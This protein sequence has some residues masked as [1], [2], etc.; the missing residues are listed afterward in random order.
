MSIGM[1]TARG[2]WGGV[3][4]DAASTPVDVSWKKWDK[5]TRGADAAALA[6]P[7]YDDST[8]P[9][10]DPSG[11][12]LTT[13]RGDSWYRGTFNVTP[14]QVDSMME[15]PHFDPPPPVKG[16]RA[17]LSRQSHRLPQRPVAVGPHRGRLQAPRRRQEHRARRHPE[18]AGWRLRPAR[19]EPLA[20]LAARARHLAFSW[21]P[22]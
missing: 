5:A 22:R 19:L 10:V 1:R 15:S 13:P 16:Q 9:A 6:K 2:L 14:A 11:L 20:Q 4:A 18:P 12:A 17:G 8:W 7:D 3:S 21:R